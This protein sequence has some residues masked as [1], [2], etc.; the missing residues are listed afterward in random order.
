MCWRTKC[1]NRTG[2]IIFMSC[3]KSFIRFSHFHLRFYNDS[4]ASPKGAS[5][6]HIH[7]SKHAPRHLFSLIR[8]PPFVPLP[9][10]VKRPSSLSQTGGLVLLKTNSSVNPVVITEHCGCVMP[11]CLQRVAPSLLPRMKFIPYSSGGEL[12]DVLS[13]INGSRLCHAASFDSDGFFSRSSG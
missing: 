13:F 8:L 9:P 3:G 7:F 6:V 5:N 1:R 10:F 4:S 11:L 2:L 12:L